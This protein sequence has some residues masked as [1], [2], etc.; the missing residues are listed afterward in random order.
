MGL[1]PERRAVTMAGMASINSPITRVPSASLLA[2]ALLLP[3]VAA[4][5]EVTLDTL[6]QDH[7]VLQ[8]D[9]AIPVRGVANPGKKV[10]VTFGSVSV[11]GTAGSDGRFS[12]AL[13]AMPAS[14]EPRELVVRGET[15]EARARDILVG[16]GW[17]C[18]GQS[19][20]EW[21]VDGADE[22]DRAKSA[23]AKLPI[24][25]FKAPHVTANE[26]KN[27][28]PGQW[29][30]ASAETVG[31]FTAVGFW[32]GADLARSF[33]LEV[34]IGLV[35]ISWGGTRIEPWIPLDEMASSDFRQRA[36][37]LRAAIDASRAIK[38]E[39][40]ARAQAEEDARYA[41]ELDGYWT[42]A[43]A[44][45]PGQ[46]AGWSKADVSLDGGA[47]GWASAEMP[48]YYPTM[49]RGLERF[50][51]FVWVARDFAVPPAIAGKPLTL[52]LPAIDDCDIV[53]IDG[54]QVGS[55]V[56][57]WTQPRRYAIPGG[58]AAGTHRITVCVLDMAGQ[59]G[60]ANGAM[61][62][63]ADGVDAIDLAGGWKWRKGGGVP[64][65]PAPMRRDVS[66]QPGTEPHEPAAI[67]NAMMAP[68]IAYPV[69]G[70][71]WYQG[72]SNAGEP[73]AYRKLLPLLMNSWRAKSG[74]P[75]M[76][77]G[78]VQLAAFMPFVENEP[79]Q[80]A[81]ALL[82]EAQ[83][84]GAIAGKGGMI[85]A[86]DLGDAADIHP[87]RKREVGER[88]AAWARNTVY[89]EQHVAWRGP[90]LASATLENGGKVR[91]RFDHAQGLRASGDAPGA[92]AL[93][94]FALAGAD[95]RFVW[96]D[97]MIMDDGRDGVMLSAPGVTDP[98]EVVYAWQNNPT[99]A[100]LV[101][102]ASLPAV[103]FRVKVA[104]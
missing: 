12:V 90:E 4:R 51:G 33:D 82:R 57:N 78:V 43:L 13:P 15:G 5:A 79:A 98:V 92:P 102:G 36:E 22:S 68:C 103:P 69:R 97:A 32:F 88:L 52:S 49:D 59:G 71:I 65:V 100:N 87:R 55:T 50:D 44:N 58:L 73:D 37:D 19:N 27:S 25:S 21:T 40:R 24:R 11:G 10:T 48:A 46:K 54:V 56:N 47:G 9:R 74:N 89:G 85:S 45:E 26:P 99:R 93:G 42:K 62:L 95:G 3:S 38:P 35:D 41:R 104:R 60:F 20:M 96:A 29:R 1:Q 66:R 94:G 8:R 34:P 28:V 39:D 64:Q 83:Y 91:L 16:E 84:R 14:R 77:W 2:G 81:W 6:F 101:N 17:F 7:A 31:G 67:Y 70:T 61:T 30:V 80:G 63:A 86:T 23:A 72:E 18:S 76:A 75:D 53:W